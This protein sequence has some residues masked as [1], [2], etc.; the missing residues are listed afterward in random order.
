VRLD[1]LESL[2]YYNLSRLWL[3][4]SNGVRIPPIR[5]WSDMDSFYCLVIDLVLHLL[6]SSNV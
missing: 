1:P 2:Y 5:S 6:F 4:T 3:N